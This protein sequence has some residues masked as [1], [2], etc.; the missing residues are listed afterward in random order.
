MDVASGGKVKVDLGPVLDIYLARVAWAR[1]GKALYVQRLSRDQRTLDLLLVDPATGASRVILKQTSPHWVELSDDLKPLK[2]G[3]FLWSDE[4]SGN[5]HIYLFTHGGKLI[6]QVTSGDWPVD[7][8]AG[9]DEKA[10]L[11][12]FGASKDAPIERQ[13]YSV[14]YKAPKA[15]HALTKGEGWWTGD[16]AKSGQALLG[17]YQD[18]STPPRTGIFKLDGALVRWIEENKVGPGHPL[19]PYVARL[20]TPA[21]GVLKAADG[22]DMHWM[23][24]TPPDFD[25]AKKYPVVIQVYGG[26]ASQTVAR[27]WLNPADQL[28]LEAGYIL[29]SLDNRGTPNRSVAF[30]T[31]IDR[32][33]GQLEVED[34]IAGVNWLK[35]QP[36]VDGGRIGITGWSNGGYMTL[37]TLS[38]PNS[39][40]AV[41]V[42]G[43]PP[44]DWRLYDTA[45]T[46]RYMGTDQDNHSGYELGDVLNRVA[47]LRSGALMLIH[48]MADDNVV[49][50]HS[51][52]LMAAL[53][54]HDIA[55]ESQLYPGLRHRAGWGAAQMRHRTE[56]TLEFF[57]RKL[58]PV[59]TP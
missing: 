6:R 45:Y 4:K 14:S 31:A 12:F 53:Q 42:A 40:I 29:F 58:K 48:G 54:A 50:I 17:T 5:R 30:K 25:P 10:G 27:K 26:P 9:V 38:A 59:P 56:A 49:F 16:V 8:I 20:R 55:F 51:T 46:E 43:A 33:I 28:Y 34:Q 3:D 52:L 18:P 23:M 19:A 1:D 21:Y 39:P 47:N 37:M 22:Q 32:R 2:D 24:R 7:A 36:F 41:G 44:T 35:T 11:V 15:P 57:N 13:I